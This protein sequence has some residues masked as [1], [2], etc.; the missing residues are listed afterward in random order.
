RP[1]TR[2][3]RKWSTCRGPPEAGRTAPP[4]APLTA[5]NP[6]H[7]PTPP[8]PR[9]RTVLHTGPRG[10][11]TSMP[12][13]SRARATA[14]D[15]ISRAELIRLLNEDLS[16]EYQAIIAYVVYSQVIKGAAYMNIAKELE[17]HA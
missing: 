10:E 3:E 16:R 15:Q 7:P 4:H 6:H 11:E 17:K 8:L 1:S 5:Q 9:Q 13:T 12:K 14:A 2:P